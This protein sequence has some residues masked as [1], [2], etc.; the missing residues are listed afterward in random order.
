VHEVLLFLAQPGSTR[1]C[2]LPS[3]S[4]LYISQY[5]LAVCVYWSTGCQEAIDSKEVD[6]IV[7]SSMNRAPHRSDKVFRNVGFDRLMSSSPSRTSCINKVRVVTL[8]MCGASS[9]SF[10]PFFHMLAQS[11]QKQYTFSVSI[12][13]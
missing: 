2:I 1:V 8:V 11:P 5:P 3:Y 10:R 12:V 4:R 9:I 13:D 7:S 6:P